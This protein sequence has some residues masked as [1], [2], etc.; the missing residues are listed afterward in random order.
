MPATRDLGRDLLPGQS[1]AEVRPDIE[2]AAELEPDHISAYNLT[3]EE[4][5][6]FFADLKRG[7]YL[8]RAG[9]LA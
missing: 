5:T 2:A 7:K 3:F 6:A 1:L 4:G 8:K 9:Y